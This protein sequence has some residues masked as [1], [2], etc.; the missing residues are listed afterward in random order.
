VTTV[1]VVDDRAINREVARMALEDG[2]YDVVEAT[3]GHEGLRLAASGHPDVI[4]TDM[5]MPGI[6]GYQ[7]AQALRRD[8]VTAEI[9]LLIYTA[10][11]SREE[12]GPLAETIGVSRILEKSATPRELLDAVAETLRASPPAPADTPAAQTARHI[13]VLNAKLL[14]KAG[15]LDESEARFAAMADASPIGII[16][17]DRRG[18]ATYANPGASEITGWLGENLLGDGWLACLG[19]D[20]Q[21]AL[22]AVDGHAAPEGRR[23][24]RRLA[25][26][27]GRDRHL[28]L[29]AREIVGADGAATGSV[30]TLDDVTAMV[31]A[32]ERRRT[33]DLER[34]AETRR[35][36]TA[37]FDSLARLAGG[38][39]HDFNNLLNII[40]SFGDF[41]DESLDEVDG[42][43]LTHECAEGM[44]HDVDRIRQAGRRAAELTHQLLTFGG[45]EV[46][47]PVSVDLN[48]VVRDAL[49]ALP[50]P[51]DQP[52]AITT[53]LA[54]DL[55]AVRADAGQMRQA[56]LSLV[57]NA[58]E[59]MPLGGRLD[60]ATENTD[61][62]DHDIGTGA[63]VRLRVT[64]TGHGMSPEVLQQA[65]EPFFTTK[66]K[67]DGPGLGLATAYG[68]VRQSGGRLVIESEPGLGT[69][70][71][72]NL[73]AAR[74]S[75]APASPAV[76]CPGPADRTILVAEDEAGLREVIVRVLRRAGFGVLPA[77]DGREAQ[78]VAEQYDGPIHALVT[79]VVMP[80][81]NGRQLAAG[82][83]V[84]RPD[85]PVLFMSGYAE[86]LMNEQGLIDADVTVLNKPF[87]HEELLAAVR[88]TLAV[89]G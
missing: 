30:V 10:N 77:A 17:T 69:T 63:Q 59:A 81:V 25:H 52:V 51:A 78:T 73:P 83:A 47:N 23:C 84:T 74:P 4:L 54:A 46:T 13:D 61:G 70:V 56:L 35:Q 19:S 87:T 21:A 12:V 32:E 16:I 18:W 66:P 28:T 1:L 5:L 80:T 34:A 48:D 14:E 3:N 7:F 44:R 2:G 79:D 71:H 27:D 49:D 65:M 20:V 50:A 76:T 88:A 57:T 86:P 11:Y 72:L 15:A 41:I 38:V 31:E 85:T 64:D 43:P 9:P 24:G 68:I 89:R 53:S 26:P 8:P 45:K 6:D 60:I 22:I 58:Y 29:L 37:R 62:T 40:L 39:A 33:D 42:A 82:L 36:A 75:A 67:G 55:H